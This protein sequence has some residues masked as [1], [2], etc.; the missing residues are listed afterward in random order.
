MCVF[1]VA[2]DGVLG[3][4]GSLGESAGLIFA[5][6]D[7]DF[8]SAPADCGAADVSVDI[9]VFSICTTVG[10]IS[11]LSVTGG[12]ATGITTGVIDGVAGVA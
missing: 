6:C 9:S 7:G 4:A 11:G 12:A 10:T 5:L 2:V 8:S 1:L 3:D